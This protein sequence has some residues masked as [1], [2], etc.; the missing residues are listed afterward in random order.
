MIYKIGYLKDVLGNNYLGIKFME[1]QL[2]PF[3]SD[4]YEIVDD[5][6]KYDVLVSNQQKRDKRDAHEYHCTVLSVMEYNRV[7]ERMGSEFQ[8]RV[9]IIHSLDIEDL[10][11]EGVGKAERAGDEAYFIV[12]KSPTLDE[13]R[14]SLGLEPKDFHITIGFDRKDVFGVRKNEVIKKKSKLR[15]LLD[16]FYSQFDGSHKWLFDIENINDNLSNVP[17]DKIEILKVTDTVATYKLDHTQIQ[18]SVINDN[19]RVVT[20][21]EF[22]ED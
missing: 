5:D 16:K 4:L 12:L 9:D 13:V 17:E 7:A 6:H 1:G 11:F 15:K 22:K 3:L 18:I 8:K 14:S 10:T 21:C 2:T 20:M 19:L